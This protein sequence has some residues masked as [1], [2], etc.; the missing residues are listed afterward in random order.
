MASANVDVSALIASTQR[1]YASNSFAQQ[2]YNGRPLMAWMQ[3]NG[4]IKT[5][6]GGIEILEPLQTA[7][8]STVQWQAS[9]T[10][11]DFSP[12]DGF[13]GATFSGKLMT[14]STTLDWVTKWQNSGSVQVIDLWEAKVNQTKEEFAVQLN[15]G[16][17]AGD[18]TTNPLKITGFPAMIGT[19]GTYGGIIRSSNSF[20]QSY[21]ET[22]A[23][24]LTDDHIRHGANV[25]SRN[26]TNNGPDLHL[27][28]QTL[29]EKYESMIL[30]AFRVEDKRMADLG[31][32]NNSLQWAGKPVIWDDEVDSG[33]WYFL[34]TKW[35]SLRPYKDANMGMSARRTPEKQLV[36]G[37]FHY[38]YGQATCKGC[39]YLGKLTAKTA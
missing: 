23:T 27:T 10:D 39:R 28:T 35:F 5:V 33:V 9:T 31:F 2:V 24:A 8:N 4:G 22:T 34:N 21:T 14:G 25:V 29:Y 6:D 17:I 38:W 12:Q 36:D 26:M 30:P 11:V 16:L 13:S 18:G 32:A 7:T 15:R 37:M 20:W 3:K 1:F 19:T